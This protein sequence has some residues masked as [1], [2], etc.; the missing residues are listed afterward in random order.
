MCSDRC[1]RRVLQIDNPIAGGR[2]WVLPERRTAGKAWLI[3]SELKKESLLE[4]LVHRRVS[5]LGLLVRCSRPG[6]R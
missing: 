4:L 3:T 2:G 6:G 1:A 5:F